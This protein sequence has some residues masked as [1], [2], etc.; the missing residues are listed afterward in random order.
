MLILLFMKTGMQLQSQRMELDHAN[1]LTDRTHRDKSSLC[2]ELGMRN[3]I[4]HLEDRA[5]NCQEIEQLRRICCAEVERARQL[6]YD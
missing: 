4:F 3:K 1:Q 6:N 2:D 5:K